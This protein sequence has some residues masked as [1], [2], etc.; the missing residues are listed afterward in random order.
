[1]IVGFKGLKLF[2]DL[3]SFVM[4]IVIDWVYVVGWMVVWVLLEFVVC[5]VFDIGVCYFVCY[6]GFE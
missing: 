3:C 6:G 4:C 2:K 5:N 1:M